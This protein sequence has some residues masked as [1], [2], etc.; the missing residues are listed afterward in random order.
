MREHGLGAGDDFADFRRANVTVGQLNRGLDAGERVSLDAVAVQLEIGHLGR[1][2]S[3]INGRGIVPA[4]EQAAIS[5]VSGLEDQLVVPERVVRVEADGRDHSA[6]ESRDGRPIQESRL[7]PVTA[8]EVPSFSDRPCCA[9]RR[10]FREGT[11]RRATVI[12][13]YIRDLVADPN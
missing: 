8:H 4:G 12:F 5:I 1:E 3:V 6:N 10:I 13:S 2:K 11:F 7:R 9:D